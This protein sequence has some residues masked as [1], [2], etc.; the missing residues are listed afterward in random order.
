MNRP[1]APLELALD[2]L[3]TPALRAARLAEPVVADI[4]Q[5]AGDDDIA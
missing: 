5:V 4:P 2:S 1:D 3:E